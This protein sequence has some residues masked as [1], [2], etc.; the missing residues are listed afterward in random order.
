MTTLA[1]K[2]FKKANVT[3]ARSLKILKTIQEQGITSSIEE[4][5]REDIRM[6]DE[7]RTR[8]TSM[9]GGI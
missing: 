9:K 5:M 4:M 3:D 2:A 6:A 1:E 7:K 8:S